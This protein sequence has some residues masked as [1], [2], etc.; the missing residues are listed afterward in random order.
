[1]KKVIDN[2]IGANALSGTVFRIDLPVLAAV[3]VRKKVV[4]IGHF[5]PSFYLQS[6]QI[7]LFVRSNP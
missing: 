3:A 6:L 1:M 7:F 2:K 5:S 4:G